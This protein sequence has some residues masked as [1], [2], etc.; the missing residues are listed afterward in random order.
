MWLEK[1]LA[2]YRVINKNNNYSI[3]SK[4]NKL[5]KIKIIYFIEFK[6]IY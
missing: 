5:K 4:L 3:K 2:Y 1:W 6:N